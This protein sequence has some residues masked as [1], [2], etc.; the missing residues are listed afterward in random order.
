MLDYLEHRG[1]IRRKPKR[2][3]RRNAAASAPTLPLQSGPEDVSAAAIAEA[4]GEAV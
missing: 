4:V 2:Q 3:S 1:L